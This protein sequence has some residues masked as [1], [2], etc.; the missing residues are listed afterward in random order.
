MSVTFTYYGAMCVKMEIADGFKVLVDPY[1]EQCP[2]VQAS[3]FFDV[4]LICVTH[5]AFDHI[6][7]AQAI[8]EG[9][10]AKLLA[11]S[12]VTLPI[13]EANPILKDRVYKTIYGDQK[14]F[15]PVTVRTMRAFH[16][17][18]SERNGVPVYGPPLG[19][20]FQM[21][22]RVTYYHTGD[23]CL[24]GDM[25]LIR[26]LYRPDVM[27]V[28]V[29]RIR[30]SGSCEMTPKEAAMAVEWMGVD[31]VIPSHYYPGSPDP[32]AFLEYMKYMAPDV[33]V[34]GEIGKSFTYVPARVIDGRKGEEK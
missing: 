17:S 22:G 30:E 26:D 19:F 7:E 2:D 15:G 3:D 20:L 6:G 5:H 32:A 9:G 18:R 28:G 1:L 13:C 4:D 16:V 8:M 33:M 21:P 12:D 29:S 31:V 27:C 11:C 23:T 25:K 24:F 34:R 14:I 10:E